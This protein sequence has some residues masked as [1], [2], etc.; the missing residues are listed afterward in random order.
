MSKKRLGEYLQEHGKIDAPTLAGALAS[1]KN[2]AEP[3]AEVLFREGLVAK[4]DLIEALQQTNYFEYL[5]PGSAE[6]DPDLLARVPKDV[7][8]RYSAIPILR[9]HKGIVVAMAEPQNLTAVHDLSFLCGA[10]I[11]PRLAFRTE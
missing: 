5:D 1:Q 6:P 9:D 10:A 3:L 8:L 2:N 4:E 7:A 11:C